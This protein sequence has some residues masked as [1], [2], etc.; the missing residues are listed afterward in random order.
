[1]PT[2]CGSQYGSSDASVTCVKLSPSS[3]KATWSKYLRLIEQR[4]EHTSWKS[5]EGLLLMGGNHAAGSWKSVEMIK[6][7][8]KSKL[9]DF[10]LKTYTRYVTLAI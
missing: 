6:A 5:S 3:D 2:M 9:L 8:G 10:S 1:M 7:N 4:F